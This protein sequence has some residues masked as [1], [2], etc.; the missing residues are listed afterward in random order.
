MGMGIGTGMKS[1]MQIGAGMGYR[2]GQSWGQGQEYESW[3]TPGVCLGG[4]GH[5]TA[6]GAREGGDSAVSAGTRAHLGVLAGAEATIRR[7]HQAL[8]GQSEWCATVS[9][10]ELSEERSELHPSAWPSP[11]SAPFGRLQD[12]RQPALTI[13]PPGGCARTAYRGARGATF[14]DT[15]TTS[16]PAL[17]NFKSHRSAC[18]DVTCTYSCPVTSCSPGQAARSIS[19]YQF[20]RWALSSAPARSVT[21]AG[22]RRSLGTRCSA[23]CRVLQPRSLPRSSTSALNVEGGATSALIAMGLKGWLGSVWSGV[24]LEPVGTP[25]STRCSVTW[26]LLLALLQDTAS[27][28]TRAPGTASSLSVTV[29][30]RSGRAGGTPQDWP[31]VATATS[32][33]L[34]HVRELGPVPRPRGGMGGPAALTC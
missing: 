32:S 17:T 30:G 22:T 25:D 24:T 16:P 26:G 1:G 13:S 28:A 31:R 33:S 27:S 29:R 3:S 23:G 15:R 2:R 7:Q 11:G 9:E 18:P 5:R 19:A 20:T 21:C 8:T 34:G 10:L 6:C 4:A 12:R 14:A